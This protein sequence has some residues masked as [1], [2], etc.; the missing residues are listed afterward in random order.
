MADWWQK[1]W[2]F[3]YIYYTVWH[4]L[5]VDSAEEIVQNLHVKLYRQLCRQNTSLIRQLQT[6]VD[7]NLLAIS[8]R[9]YYQ[10][11]GILQI[12]FAYWQWESF[13]LN[14]TSPVPFSHLLTIIQF[15]YDHLTTWEAL[16]ILSVF[17]LFVIFEINCICN[18]FTYLLHH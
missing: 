18:I 16:M 11:A 7:A 8:N 1:S 13:S 10:S 4:K 9:M 3:W 6:P 5:I 12:A 2:R 15:L 14:W 17:Y